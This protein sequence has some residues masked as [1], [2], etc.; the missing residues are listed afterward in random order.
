MRRRADELELPFVDVTAPEFDADPAA[1]FARARQQSWLART[2]EGFAVL[3]HTQARAVFRHPALR[4]AF[5]HVDVRSS[6]Y[7]YE[8]TRGHIQALDGSEHARL[9]RVALGALRERVVER[10]REPMRAIVSD[11]VDGVADRGSCDVVREITDPYPTRVVAPL[12][13]VPDEDCDRIDAWA[14]ELLLIFDSARFSV[15]ASRVERAWREIEVYLSDLLD[16][17][18]RV[19]GDDIYSELVRAEAGGTVSADELITLAIALTQA[20]IDT[21]RG[22][23]GATMESLVRRP[24]QWARLVAD[25]G[26]AEQA[27][28]EGLR[29]APAVGSI[30]HVA[31][32]DAELDDVVF[33]EGSVVAVHPRA[34]NRDPSAFEDPDRFDIGRDAGAHFSFGFGAHACLGSQLARIEM[35]E[36]LR[37]LATRFADW[38][39]AGEVR[40]QP[41]S[42][43]GNLLSLPVRFRTLAPA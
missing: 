23:L 40:R 5:A 24:E 41:M 22:Q 34:V 10:L 31:T 37:V 19:P 25:P 29:F 35:A 26:L 21:T 42:S 15:L 18:R 32:V 2:S 39:L 12:L 20:A 16:E 17:R 38:T 30:P 7:L 11:L 4:F 36:A 3:G 33:P 43:N 14:S 9:R 8:K 27:V 1:V 13:G 28:E 6:P